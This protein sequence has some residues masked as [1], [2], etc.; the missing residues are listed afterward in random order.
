MKEETGLTWDQLG[1]IFGVSRRA[2]HLWANGGR[3]NAGNAETLY[4]LMSVV[5][6]LPGE[7]SDER[8]MALLALDKDGRS[9][10]DSYRTRRASE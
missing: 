2:V 9:I 3:M 7:N 5:R 6:S 1:R 8:R 10:V 4:D